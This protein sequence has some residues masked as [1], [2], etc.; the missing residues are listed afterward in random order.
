VGTTPSAQTKALLAYLRSQQHG[1]KY[2]VAAT[3]SQEAGPLIMAGAS[4][5]PMGGFTGQVPFPTTNQ[6]A[7]LVA[8]GQLRYVLVGGGR[9]FG[10]NGGNNTVQTWVTSNCQAVDASAY[11]GGTAS[12]TAGQDFGGGGSLYDCRANA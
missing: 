9:G 8:K 3:G 4:V 12:G 11:G 10:G 6:L 7:S 5:L 2:L 1:E